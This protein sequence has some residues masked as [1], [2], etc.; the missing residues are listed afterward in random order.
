MIMRGVSYSPHN[1]C[2][3]ET[4]ETAASGEALAPE[5]LLL[6]KIPHGLWLTT[7]SQQESMRNFQK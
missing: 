3:V 4:G 1:T 6:L 7:R 2:I 5:P